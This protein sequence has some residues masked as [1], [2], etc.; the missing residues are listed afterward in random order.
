[1][2]WQTAGDGELLSFVE[3]DS[4]IDHIRKAMVDV[5]AGIPHALLVLHL[6]R[7]ADV[8]EHCG[9]EAEPALLELVGKTLIEQT[10]PALCACRVAFDEFALVKGRCLPTEA[11]TLGRRLR[12]ALEGA[13]FR[14][15]DRPF[16]LGVSIAVVEMGDELR[17]AS[18][19]L[20]SAIEACNAAKSLGGDGILLIEGDAD[21]RSLLQ[22]EQQW[23]DHIREILG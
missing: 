7:F 13:T 22:A 18:A 10:V 1:M 5:G 9:A 8:V 23:R 21:P 4:L 12:G 6:E 19:T 15:S 2:G 17:Q 14:W 16:R 3:R 11:A 20:E